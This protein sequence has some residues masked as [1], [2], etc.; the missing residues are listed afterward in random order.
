MASK[1]VVKVFEAIG[2]GARVEIINKP[3]KVVLKE[4]AASDR[5]A[6]VFRD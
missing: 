3:L 2:V 5:L 4:H 6:Q 1:D